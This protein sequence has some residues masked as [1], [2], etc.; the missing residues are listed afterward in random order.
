MC[1]HL[2]ASFEKTRTFEELG[3][4]QSEHFIMTFRK[5][6]PLNYANCLN[7]LDSMSV[8]NSNGFESPLLCKSSHS[9]CLLLVRGRWRPRTRHPLSLVY[10]LFGDCRCQFVNSGKK[11]PW[12]IKWMECCFVDWLCWLSFYNFII[13]QT[14][15]ACFSPNEPH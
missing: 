15:I 7:Q 14:K 11:N 1:A 5:K 9:S 4:L 3:T 8:N 2:Q 12:K 10:A 6:L 13:L